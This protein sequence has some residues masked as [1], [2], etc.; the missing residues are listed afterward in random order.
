[1]AC[2]GVIALWGIV[3][4]VFDLVGSVMRKELEAQG[5]TGGDLDGA[6]G[7]WK[8][9]A[10]LMLNIGAFSGMLAFTVVHSADESADGVCGR[11]CGRGD[12]PRP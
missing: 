8:G 11:V 6:V 12:A 9:T 5:L 2:T 3:F 4:F 10:S 7:Q 1:M